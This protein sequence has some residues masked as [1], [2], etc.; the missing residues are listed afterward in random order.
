MVIELFY[1]SE[2]YCGIFVF[3]MCM[4]LTLTLNFAELNV[5]MSIDIPHA[6]SSY[7]SGNFCPICQRWRDNHQ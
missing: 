3:G 2:R 1:L 5:D 6:N 4:A 7:Y